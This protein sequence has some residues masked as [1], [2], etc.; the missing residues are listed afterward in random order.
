[1]SG[2]ESKRIVHQ[3]TASLNG[4]A[5]EVFAYLPR[6]VAHDLVRALEEDGE[7]FRYDA[8]AQRAYLFR[9]HETAI[10]VW[11][12]D[13]VRS[14]AEYSDLVARLERLESPLDAKR[15]QAAYLDAIKSR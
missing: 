3:L 15:A 2:Q 4:E 9:R 12:W 13:D 7:E 5:D 11:T 1:M 14:E 10:D 8:T 6:A